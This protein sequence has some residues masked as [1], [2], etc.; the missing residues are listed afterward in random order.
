MIT[1]PVKSTCTST[2][3]QLSERVGAGCVPTA[4]S[5]HSNIDPSNLAAGAVLRAKTLSHLRGETASEARV[6]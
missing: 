5:F 4:L 3:P 2:T 1:N 6:S